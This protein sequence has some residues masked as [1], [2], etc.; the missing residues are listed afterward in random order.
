MAKSYLVYNGSTSCNTVA[1]IIR[2]V[3]CQVKAN[4]KMFQLRFTYPKPSDLIKSR[5]MWAE[6]VY[7]AKYQ[8]DF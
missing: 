4:I 6:P 1:S 2:Q 5:P 8:D 7:V 3:V